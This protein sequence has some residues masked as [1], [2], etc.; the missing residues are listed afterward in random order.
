MYR[1]STGL[2]AYL[3]AATPLL[4]AQDTIPLST[5]IPALTVTAQKRSE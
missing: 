2:A 3:L 5:D 4:Q 1:L